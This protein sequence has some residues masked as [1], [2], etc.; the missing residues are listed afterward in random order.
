ME[1]FLEA[2]LRIMFEAMKR[3]SPS[4]IV[5]VEPLYNGVD[6]STDIESKAGGVE[7]SFSHNYPCLAKKAG[8]EMFFQEVIAGKFTW[9]LMIA[10]E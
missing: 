4:L 8:F 3:Q 9:L 10:K 1:Y 7:C 2:E 5:L 6:L